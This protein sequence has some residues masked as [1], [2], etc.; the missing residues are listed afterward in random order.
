MT[1]GS[2]LPRTEAGEKNMKAAVFYGKQDIRI[3]DIP[4]PKVGDD[5]VLIRVKACGVC[6]TDVHIYHGDQGSADVVPPRVLGHEFSGMVEEVGKN[7]TEFQPGDRVCADPNKLCGA[8]YYCRSGIG[9]FCEHMTIY[10]VSENGGFAQFCS[11][12]K[13]QVLKLAAWTAYH[14]G[15]MAEPVSC[16]LHGMDMCN[17]KSGQ[18]V[19]VIDGG[20]IGL[21]MIQLAVIAGASRVALIEPVEGKREM[22]EKLGAAVCIDPASQDVRGELE[23]SGIDRLDAV[24]ECVGLPETME[25]A[26]ELAGR[27]S[28]AMLFGLSSPEATITVKPFDLF[29]REVDIKA[30]YIN[31]YTIDRAA[32]LINSRRIDVGF[33]Q[34]DPLPLERLADAVSDPELRRQGKL[35]IDP[36]L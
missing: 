1:T 9:H 27:K 17:I 14:E 4:M 6:G 36:A 22:G 32:E 19:A 34:C 25:Q 3:E 7:V 26:I 15:A 33:M 24:I 12:N 2:G 28:V 8:C 16:C 13:S 35:I 10:G 11:V 31:P 29:R 5:D 30:S 18:K 20:M 23:K 21:I